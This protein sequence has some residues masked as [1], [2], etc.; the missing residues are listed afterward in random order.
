MREKY[1]GIWEVRFDIGVAFSGVCLLSN[2]QIF[3]LG[4]EG[5]AIDDFRHPG[6]VGDVMRQLF[7][8]D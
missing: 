3:Q 6:P 8:V 4:L 7:E 1:P 2:P 5:G